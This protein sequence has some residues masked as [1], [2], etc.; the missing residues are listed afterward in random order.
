MGKII[1]IIEKIL[2]KEEVIAPL[3]DPY[4]YTEKLNSYYGGSLVGKNILIVVSNQNSYELVTEWS[5]GFGTNVVIEKYENLIDIESS[6][7]VLIGPFTNIINVIYDDSIDNDS[8]YNV[9]NLLQIES[10]Y[11]I[12]VANKGSIS[13]AF[14]TDI[15]ESGNAVLSLIKG[16]S[17][18]LGKHGI[19]ENGLI[20]DKTVKI[21]DILNSLSYL[22][23]KYGYILAGE[24][25]ILAEDKGNE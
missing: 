13:T 15:N 10:D 21:L 20:A 1:K 4:N 25:L 22:N 24:V 17:W 8:V 5:H 11:L 7:K 3:V 16:L 12:E 2:G 14:I 18:A 9:Y 6:S 23:S 19:I